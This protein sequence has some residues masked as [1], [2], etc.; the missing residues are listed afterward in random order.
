MLIAPNGLRFSRLAGCAGLG[1]IIYRIAEDHTNE[2]SKPKA[3]SA[4]SAG[5]ALYFFIL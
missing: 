4:A 5:W 3:K 2:D 1:S